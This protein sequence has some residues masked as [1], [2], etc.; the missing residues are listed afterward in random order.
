MSV[1]RRSAGMPIRRIRSLLAAGKRILTRRPAQVTT[2]EA[3]APGRAWQLTGHPCRQGTVQVHLCLLGDQWACHFPGVVR[4]CSSPGEIGTT[5][6]QE[7]SAGPCRGSL[8]LRQA[9][10]RGS[11]PHRNSGT[12]RDYPA[13]R[14]KFESFRANYLRGTPTQELFQQFRKMCLPEKIATRIKSAETMENA[15]IRLDA[16]FGDKGLFIKDLMQDIKNVAPIKDGDDERLMD[17][18]VM[19]Q[20]HIAE[21]CNAELL[22]MLLILAN[23]ELMVV[24]LTAWEK[25]V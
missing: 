9:T 7:A 2:L 17:Y 4:A 19:L 21:A 1:V 25:R 20:A 10:G 18:Y 13:F 15:W 3:A 11:P 23:V 24:P 6:L 22:Y 8:N 5:R 16:W 14:R 12:F